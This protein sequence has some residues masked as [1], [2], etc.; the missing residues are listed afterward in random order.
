M[1][2]NSTPKPGS[3]ALV[4]A[5]LD[6]CQVSYKPRNAKLVRLTA[7]ETQRDFNRVSFSLSHDSS[8]KGTS[9]H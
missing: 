6:A 9:V 3:C 2:L 5:P 7:R 4:K 1:A 8:A